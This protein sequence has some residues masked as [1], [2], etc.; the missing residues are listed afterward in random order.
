M[1]K[2]LYIIIVVWKCLD[3]PA[4]LFEQLQFMGLL[5]G[6]NQGT[7]EQTAEW[8]NAVAN[9]A[10]DLASF[11]GSTQPTNSLNN[12][13]S[14]TSQQQRVNIWLFVDSIFSYWNELGSHKSSL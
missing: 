8:K 2:N 7:A 9:G 10:M 11:F 3:A 1:F 14:Q 5:S 12:P 4:S 13:I 6:S